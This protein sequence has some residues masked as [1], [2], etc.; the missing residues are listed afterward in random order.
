MSGKREGEIMK[1][2]HT[3][4]EITNQPDAWAEAL[5]VVQRQAGALEKL[6][7]DS[8]QQVVFTGCG[9][10]F[11]LS[12]A[13]ASL[14][15]ELTG[16]NARAIPASELLLNPQTILTGHKTLLVAVSRSGSTTETVKA[17]EYFRQP[18]RAGIGDYQLW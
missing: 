11:Y 1:H 12:L 16:W 9:S 17:V 2:F 15:Q 14:Y 18:T 4:D 5:Q 8:I 6:S 7:G 3:L 10:T 13:G